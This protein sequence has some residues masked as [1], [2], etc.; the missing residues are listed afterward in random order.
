MLAPANAFRQPITHDAL[1]RQL[2]Y[3]QWQ[4]TPRGRLDWFLDDLKMQHAVRS[5]Y[6]SGICRR[7][8]AG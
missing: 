3:T 2:R 1:Q 8:E 6:G 4:Q 7:K 5:A